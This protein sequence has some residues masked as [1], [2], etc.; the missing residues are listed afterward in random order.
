MNVVFNFCM[1]LGTTDGYNSGSQ[2]SEKVASAAFMDG[3]FHYENILILE[4]TIHK[5]SENLKYCKRKTYG[6]YVSIKC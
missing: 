2:F 5:F 3:I 1:K 6:M 4:L